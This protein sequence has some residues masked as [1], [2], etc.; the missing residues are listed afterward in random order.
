[1]NQNNRDACS[2]SESSEGLWVADMTQEVVPQIVEMHLQAFEGYMGER[3]GPIYINAQFRWFQQNPQAISIV[4]RD[5]AGTPLGYAIGAETNYSKGMNRD[6]LPH[7]FVAVL[8]RPRLLVDKQIV[9][10]ALSRLKLLIR[11]QE[12][13]GESLRLPEPTMALVGIGVSPQAH[14]QGIGQKLLRA[15]GDRSK[16][17]GAQSMLLSVYPNNHGARKLYEKCGWEPGSEP[18]R[19]DSTMYYVQRF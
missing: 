13:E 1:M 3:M 16:E 17:L 19:D 11:K 9:R 18:N 6:L 12:T 8:T 10:T 7:A 4:V 2:Q 15:F 5:H 14:G